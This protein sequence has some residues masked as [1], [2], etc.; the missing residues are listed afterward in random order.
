MIFEK[1]LHGCMWK[2]NTI[3]ASSEEDAKVLHKF[4]REAILDSHLYVTKVIGFAIGA[5]ETS[6]Q[7]DTYISRHSQMG[8]SY[9]EMMVNLQDKVFINAPDSELALLLEPGAVYVKEGY[10]QSF[11]NQIRT[12]STTPYICRNL[13]K[14]CLLQLRLATSCG[15]RSIDTNSRLI[16]ES[17][18][19]MYTYFNISDYV[20]VI[21]RREG[22]NYI[23]LSF[24]NGFTV[25]DFRTI[26]ENNYKLYQQHAMRK[27]E[28]RWVQSFDL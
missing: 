1:I 19:P 26:L 20:R 21:P 9:V 6:N 12:L 24:Y 23:G 8:D 28:E 13:S 5:A 27:G 7:S 17:Y 16:D 4:L 25:E 2:G 11:R 3:I 15:Y 14:E 22:L 18:F 10:V